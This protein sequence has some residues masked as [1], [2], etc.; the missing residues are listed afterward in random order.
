MNGNATAEGSSSDPNANLPY[1][2]GGTVGGVV[3]VGIVLLL[4]LR[5]HRHRQAPS[6]A[7]AAGLEGL[8]GTKGKTW[9]GQ[10]PALHTADGQ[11]LSA[12]AGNRRR[13]SANALAPL[14]RR[15]S[16][17]DGTLR[18]TLAPLPPSAGSL[19]SPEEGVE[20]SP[21]WRSKEPATSPLKSILKKDPP[22]PQDGGM[23]VAPLDA[24]GASLT[25]QAR[26]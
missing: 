14:D 4:L 8:E 15:I 9:S 11:P 21:S 19:P 26:M 23:K 24:R 5:R 1:I 12:P 6:S 18:L 10:A 2:I 13:L 20:V 25:P 7:A 22:S 17:R 16:T 3:L